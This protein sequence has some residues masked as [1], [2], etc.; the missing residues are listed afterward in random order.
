LTLNEG[1]V[2]KKVKNELKEK[3]SL[4]MISSN[5]EYAPYDLSI[6]EIRE[7]WKFVLY[8]TG[9]IPA[10]SDNRQIFNNLEQIRKEIVEIRHQI[11][12]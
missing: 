12:Q 1:I 4:K 8:M 3:G 2:F 7:V 9:E 11:T 6:N 5:P 10:P